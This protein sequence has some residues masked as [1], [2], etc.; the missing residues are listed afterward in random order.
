[1]QESAGRNSA[2]RKRGSKAEDFTITDGSLSHAAITVSKGIE[3]ILWACKEIIPDFS[4][5]A[6]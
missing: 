3:N 4:S 5:M 2:I 1:M 6:V